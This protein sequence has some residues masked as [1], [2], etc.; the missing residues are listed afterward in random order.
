[1]EGSDVVEGGRGGTF[2][3]VEGARW[4]RSDSSRERF[5]EGSKG[6]TPPFSESLV[7]RRDLEAMW[8]EGVTTGSVAGRPV[9]EQV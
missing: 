1:M 6:S 7:R 8:P 2:W 4:M 3:V 9:R 5:E